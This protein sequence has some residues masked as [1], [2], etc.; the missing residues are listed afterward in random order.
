[1]KKRHFRRQEPEAEWVE[2][3]EW[4]ECTKTAFFV[5]NFLDFFMRRRTFQPGGAFL[6][7]RKKP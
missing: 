7:S 1:M 2:W 4:V 3:A 5:E 6:I